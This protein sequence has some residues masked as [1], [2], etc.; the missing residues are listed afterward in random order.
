MEGGALPRFVF[1]LEATHQQN[2]FNSPPGRPLLQYISAGTTFDTKNNA[3]ALL[4]AT[5]GSIK[6]LL[7]VSY[8]WVNPE[9]REG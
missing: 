6:F 8:E 5:N 4:L 9:F 3:V 1:L 7:T 2:C